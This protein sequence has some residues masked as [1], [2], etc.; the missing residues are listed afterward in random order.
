M[1]SPENVHL[2]K[3]KLKNLIILNLSFNILYIFQFKKKNKK[4]QHSLIKTQRYNLFKQQ[5][6]IIL[7]KVSLAKLF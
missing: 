3:T 4:V 2:D 1:I 7:F 6:D 5:I